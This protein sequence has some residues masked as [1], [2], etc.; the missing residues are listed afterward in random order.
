MPIYEFMCVSTA[1]RPSRSSS[2]TA[3]GP[4]ARG[5]PRGT[6]GG[7]CRGSPFIRL[8]RISGGRSSGK[9]C[10]SCASSSVP[11]ATDQPGRRRVRGPPPRGRELHALCAARDTHA[12]GV[13]RGRPS[14]RPMFVGEAPGYHE[15]Q[16]GRP[17]VGSAGKLL[18]E[19]LA[20]IG[21]RR[22]QV[23][24][25]NVLKSR[26]PDNRDPRPDE[27]GR[28]RAVPVAPDRANPAG[29]GAE[30]WQ[31]RHQA[32]LGRADGH[33]PSARPGATA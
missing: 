27:I 9:S 3:P 32:A 8:R 4:C 26:P 15:D 30:P 22:G 6:C 25:A 31:L 5:A 7:S 21:M 14:R 17:F 11:P 12:G 28:P 23:F 2:A 19:L 20:S 1:R 16:Q 10:S 18:E 33:H 13:R 24:I 29:G